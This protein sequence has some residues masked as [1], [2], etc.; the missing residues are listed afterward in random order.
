MTIQPRA[1]FVFLAM[2]NASRTVLIIE[3]CPELAVLYQKVLSPLKFNLVVCGTGTAAIEFLN[4][5]NPQVIVTDLTLPDMATEV[6]FEKFVS[7]PNTE[8]I[9]LIL[10]SGRDDL[11]SWQ[12]LF[13]A[14]YALKKPTDVIKFRECVKSLMP[15]E[16]PLEL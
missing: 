6:F 1:A 7:L 3:D 11:S 12:D 10:I 5:Q 2:S 14:K 8:A 13:E 15:S 16:R 9:P 4:S